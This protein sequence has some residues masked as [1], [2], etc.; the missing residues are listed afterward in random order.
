MTNEKLTI[1]YINTRDIVSNNANDGYFGNYKYDYAINNLKTRLNSIKSQ[2]DNG[3]FFHSDCSFYSAFGGKACD[4]DICVNLFFS[5]SLGRFAPND[6]ASLFIRIKSPNTDCENKL[7]YFILDLFSKL[8]GF[9]SIRVNHYPKYKNGNERINYIEIAAIMTTE[10]S[11]K[12][13]ITLFNNESWLYKHM[14]IT[15]ENWSQYDKNGVID[16]IMA[17][18]KLT[19]NDIIDNE[20]MFYSKGNLPYYRYW[21][22]DITNYRFKN[23]SQSSK[24]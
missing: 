13:N 14:L 6:G 1:N 3:N 8:D 19:F 16:I 2:I 20:L 12:E 18:D 11:E 24:K 10:D 17:K 22:H 7:F 9:Q 15:P 21:S 23:N 4:I 5:T